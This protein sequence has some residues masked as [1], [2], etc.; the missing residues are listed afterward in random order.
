MLTVRARRSRIYSVTWACVI[1]F[2]VLL[3]GEAEGRTRHRRRRDSFVVALQPFLLARAAVHAIAEPLVYDAPRVLRNVRMAES[4]NY[5]RAVQ[6]AYMVPRAQSATA[7]GADEGEEDQDRE[8]EAEPDIESSGSRPI[9]TGSRAVLRNGVAYAPSHAPE[10]V[11][12]AIWAANGLRRKPYVWGGGHCSFADRGYDCSGTVSF[13]LHNAGAIGSPLPSSE[14]MRF[15]E[16]GRGRWFTIYAHSGH[17]FAVIA[18]L[19]LD[20]T[21]FQNGGNVGPR[22]H[23]DMRDTSGYIARHPGGM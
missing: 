13:A 3:I 19:R 15:G 22:W 7:P 17:T 6:L 10:N 8:R 21:D 1:A 12:N 5:G 14:L 4:A 16:R 20:T 11:K 2:S 18:G 9:V 23:T